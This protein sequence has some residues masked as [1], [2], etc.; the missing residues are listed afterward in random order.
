M[1]T[2]KST[3]WVCTFPIGIKRCHCKH[4]LVMAIVRGE[5]DCPEEAKRVLIGRKCK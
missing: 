3:G 4:T 5:V 1:V 2:K